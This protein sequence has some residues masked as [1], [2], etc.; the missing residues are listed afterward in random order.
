[1][2]ETAKMEWLS[3]FGKNARCN[4]SVFALR[5]ASFKQRIPTC[6][7]STRSNTDNTLLRSQPEMKPQ[8]MIG[9]NSVPRNLLGLNTLYK[10]GDTL[11]SDHPCSLQPDQFHSV[12]TH[13]NSAAVHKFLF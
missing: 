8:H 1:M 12:F 4:S 7:T 2:G 6:P 11:S 10:T 9:S 5:A 3:G 13:I